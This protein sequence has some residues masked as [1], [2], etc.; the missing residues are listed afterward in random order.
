MQVLLQL[1]HSMK[2]IVQTFE[3]IRLELDS[4]GPGNER[5]PLEVVKWD[6]H[7]EVQEIEKSERQKQ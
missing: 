4:M 3:L 7:C 1:Q 6:V 2:P 5:C